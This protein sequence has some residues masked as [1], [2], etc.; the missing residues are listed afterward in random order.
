MGSKKR[1]KHPAFLWSPANL[2][3]MKRQ[4]RE[5]VREDAEPPPGLP[6][7]PTPGHPHDHEFMDDLKDKNDYT[8]RVMKRTSKVCIFYYS[9]AVCFL[10]FFAH[11]VVAEVQRLHPAIR[12]VGRD[13]D[14]PSCEVL[15]MRSW[16]SGPSERSTSWVL[17]AADG[18]A[19]PSWLGF[20][21]LGL[22]RHIHGHQGCPRVAGHE[23]QGFGFPGK[24]EIQRFEVTSDVASTRMRT[25]LPWVWGCLI[26]Q[27][28]DVSSICMGGE[29]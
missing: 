29:M 23:R 17:W 2:V 21:S 11:M 16:K 8:K 5:P 25:P 13:T 3:S 20:D 22:L 19:V 28:T 6:P 26:L 27:F 9:S 12:P 24:E 1:T 15:Q 10:D 7:I 18:Q 4:Q 14:W